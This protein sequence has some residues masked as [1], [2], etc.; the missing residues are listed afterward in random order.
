M[1]KIITDKELLKVL[2]GIMRGTDDPL[3]YSRLLE[4]L[5]AVAADHTGCEVGAVSPPDDI[6]NAWTVS[7][8][9]GD[10][11]LEEFWSRYD[12]DGQL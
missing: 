8:R 12:K 5:A 4:D 2:G 7:I 9:A 10:D 1:A 6:V 3:T 11:P